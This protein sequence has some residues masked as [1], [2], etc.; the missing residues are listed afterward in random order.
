MSGLREKLDEILRQGTQAARVELYHWELARGGPRAKLTV[1]IDTPAGVTLADCER[2]SRA[3]EALLDEQDPIAYPYVLE[4]SSP[5]LERR[6]WEERHYRQALGKRIKVVLRRPRGRRTVIIG[7]LT[8]VTGQGI[9]VS[10]GDD[11]HRID[12]PDIS[13]AQLVYE[14]EGEAI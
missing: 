2:T 6:L 3:I 4:V 12:F 5:G 10:E 11:I 14:P 1:Y 13:R 9:E 7:T 8:Q